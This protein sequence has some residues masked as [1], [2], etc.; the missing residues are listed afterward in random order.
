MQTCR[1]DDVADTNVG[2]ACHLAAFAVE[3]IFKCLIIVEWLFQSVTFAIRTGLLGS[4][5][6]IVYRHYWT[7]HSAQP[8]SMDYS[9]IEPVL[10]PY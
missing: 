2:W 3:A 10:R 9:G 4:G 8:D 7:I 5:E 1:L 6:V